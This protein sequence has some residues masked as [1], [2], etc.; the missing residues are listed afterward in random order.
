MHAALISVFT[1]VVLVGAGLVICIA[2]DR[3]EQRWRIKRFR[4]AILS[5]PD[6][7]DERFAATLTEMD[8]PRVLDMRR[9]LA[10]LLGIDPLKIQAEWRFREE[11]HLKN[12]DFAIFHAF[13]ERYAPDR[14]RD[15]RSFLFPT[16]EVSTVRDLF[17]EAWK[18]E[19]NG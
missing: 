9:M 6:V 19:N 7:P 5:K 14:L 12:M 15:Q 2:S 16:A 18:L 8:P 13:A 17:L 1:V 10:A 4:R 3:I 11:R